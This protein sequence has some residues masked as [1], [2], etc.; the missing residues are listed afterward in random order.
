MGTPGM[1][2]GKPTWTLGAV[3]QGFEEGKTPST[4]NPEP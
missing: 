2:R 3:L 1:R 4:L